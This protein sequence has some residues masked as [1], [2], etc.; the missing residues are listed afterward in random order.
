MADGS[1]TR[2]V[3]NGG[4]AASDGSSTRASAKASSL[5]ADGSSSRLN[6]TGAVSG[7]TPPTN[8]PGSVEVDTT[9]GKIQV[10]TSTGKIQVGL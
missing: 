6:L 3:A 5:A 9:T 10:D 2:M 8:Q 4:S 7:V 1:E